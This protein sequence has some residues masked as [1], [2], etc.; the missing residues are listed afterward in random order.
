M[1]EPTDWVDGEQ[2]DDVTRVVPVGV[3]RQW[4]QRMDNDLAAYTAECAGRAAD[5]VLQI[6]HLERLKAERDAPLIA[7]RLIAQIAAGA[8]L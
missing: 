1:S 2:N 5:A 6:A 8:R 3:L 7:L 4:Q